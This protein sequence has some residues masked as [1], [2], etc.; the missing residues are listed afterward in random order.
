MLYLEPRWDIKL[1]NV[2]LQQRFIMGIAE[3]LQ[4]AFTKPWK[5]LTAE[6]L[7]INE[8]EHLLKDIAPPVP[9]LGQVRS[10]LKHLKGEL[11]PKI[12][13]VLFERTLKITEYVIFQFLIPLLRF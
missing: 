8:I 9:S 13:F 3:Q 4:E 2:R 1:Y 10:Y 12:K 11:P 6:A 5:D 7:N